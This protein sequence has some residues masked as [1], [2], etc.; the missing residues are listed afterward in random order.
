[1]VESQKSEQQ[2]VAAAQGAPTIA[3]EVVAEQVCW[4]AGPLQTP[5]QHSAL[6]T[7][8][9]PGAAQLDPCEQT[10]PPS[11]P[12][13]VHEP[14]QHC[15]AVEQLMPSARH[16]PASLKVPP[17]SVMGVPECELLQPATDNVAAADNTM[18]K[19]TSRW[20]MVMASK[21]RLPA[22]RAQETPAGR[23]A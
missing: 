23:H 2:S 10:L 13:A 6:D 8:A 3:H 16:I 12:V 9:E 14:E 5:E 18:A 4:P 20:V 7:H 21:L 19:R 22:R 1:L 11:V 15:P 17:A